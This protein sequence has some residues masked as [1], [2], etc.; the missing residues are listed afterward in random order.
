[1]IAIII[2][3]VQLLG[4]VMAVYALLATRTSQGTVAWVVTLIAFPWLG[5]PAYLIFG[6]TRYK[7]YVSSRAEGEQG[8]RKKL[9][10][11][12]YKI[13][14]YFAPRPQ[15][16]ESLRAFEVLAKLPFTEANHIKLLINGQVTFDDIFTGI[17]Q[18]KD[19]I[20]IQFYIIKDDSLG[21]LLSQHLQDALAR[22]VRVFLLYDEIGS[23]QLDENYL[24]KL[25]DKGAQV[26]SFHS[27]RSFQNRF[28]LNFR[29]HRK[30]IVIDGKHSWIGGHNVGDEYIQK[31]PKSPYWRDTH[32]KLSGPVVMGAQHSFIEDWLWVTEQLPD[33]NWTPCVPDTKN[34]QRAVILPSGPSDPFE[35]ASLMM[36]HSIHIAKQRIW[37]ASPYFVPDEGVQQALRLAALRGVDVRI[38]IPEKPDNL[39]IYL[40]AFAFLPGILKAGV[41]IM[42]YKKGFLHQKVFLIDSYLSAVGTANM[43]NRSF[44]LNFEITALID[45]V[46]FASQ[47]EAMLLEDF[48]NA[49]AITIE[50]IKAKPLWFTILCRAAYLSAPVQ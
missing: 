27:H 11:V 14:G 8:A 18:A 13:S 29:N 48:N 50:E 44:R 39:L 30:V 9:D 33:L 38:L 40:S 1:M 23:Y 21:E 17:Q 16:N 24:D 4:L 49:G 47:V 26:H 32:I 28:Q 7:G 25:T 10:S 19:Y 45:D 12:K 43:D 6:R 3:A 34:Y 46:Y 42:R 22:G 31:D 35:T 2:T 5:I 37:I 36:Q 41:K 15:Q 20:L